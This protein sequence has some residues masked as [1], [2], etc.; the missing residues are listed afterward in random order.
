MSADDGCLLA[1]DEWVDSVPLLACEFCS[2]AR[3]VF[4]GTGDNMGEFR[5]CASCG[6]DSAGRSLVAQRATALLG[7]EVVVTLDRGDD[8][9]AATVATGTLLAWADSGE[10]VVRDEM[11][12]VHHCWPMLDVATLG[13][14]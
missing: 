11:G 8:E 5:R 3:G 7:K 6:R 2:S 1:D 10:V 12:F 4:G 14:A 9:T 13:G